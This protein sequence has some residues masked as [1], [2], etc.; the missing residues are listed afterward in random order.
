MVAVLAA[1][2][3]SSGGGA[4]GLLI[5]LP[6]ILVFYFFMIRPQRQRMRQHSQVIS[7]I[8]SGDEVETIG[9][10]YGTIREVHDDTFSIEISPGTTVRV[11]RG[12]VR[13][14]VVEEE[15][16]ESPGSGT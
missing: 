13:R 1:Q 12:A 15:E 6:L 11:S 4:A 2:S 10:I 3:G 16:E 8:E 9:G 7:S 14:K 5:L